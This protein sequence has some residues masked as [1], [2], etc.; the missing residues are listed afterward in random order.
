MNIIA[1]IQTRCAELGFADIAVS[2]EH[3]EILAHGDYATSVAL[4]LAK[5]AGKL[6][7]AMAD[8][9][10]AGLKMP[11]AVAS[12]S[13]AGPGFINFTL[14]QDFF[15]D[16]LNVIQNKGARWGDGET[17]SGREVILEH[18]SPNL[19]KPFHIG[20]LVNNAIGES[21]VRLLTSQGAHVTRLSYP[22]D[23]SP[24]IAKAVW[25]LSQSLPNDGD[26]VAAQ[27]GAAYAKG[28]QAYDSDE[29]AKREI[30]TITKELYEKQE[31]AH[32]KIYKEG[33][34]ASLSYFKKKTSQL[35]SEFDGFIYESETE[36]V[37]KEIVKRETPRVFEISNGAYIFRGSAHG[38]FDNVFIN[39][40][41]F[42]TYLGKDIGLLEK[43]FTLYSFD[44]SITVTDIEQKPHF[45][46]LKKSAE[47]IKPEWAEKSLFIHHG[48]LQFSGGK[49]SS[50]FGNVPLL[51]DLIA[52]VEEK[53]YPRLQEGG[54]IGGDEIHAVLEQIAIAALKFS[55]LRSAPGTN[56]MFDFEKSTAIEGDTGPY[57]QYAHARCSSLLEKAKELGIKPCALVKEHT[58]DLERTLYRFPEVVERAATELQPHY[59]AH[60]AVAVA[61]LFNSWYAETQVLD[62]GADVPHKLAIV[63]ATQITLRN[64]LNLLGIKAPEKM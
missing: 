21:L 19:F 44:T 58:S 49:V 32:L 5:R 36:E 64:A 45:M 39:S 31:G 35:G 13:V 38:L 7:R 2:L 41:G 46:L 53:V 50:R 24:G 59:V 29:G 52:E 6:P 48:R 18:S 17:R 3:P 23:I 25:A 14:K 9:I 42:A 16:S 33:I 57:V 54:R 40:A 28:V 12:V 20:H 60:F 51:E 10:V 27:L 62:A 26:L 15:S 11:T 47:L 61:S 22:S 55:I 63:A 56:I 4:A 43:K 1:S 34:N 8:E 37:G 30:D